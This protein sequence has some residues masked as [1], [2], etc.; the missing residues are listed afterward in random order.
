MESNHSNKHP[1]Q[2]TLSILVNGAETEIPKGFTVSDLVAEMGLANKRVAV[3]RNLDIVPRSQH[4][5][6]VLENN[7]K[8]EV[9]EA[10][11]GG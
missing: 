11:G 4:D 6:V 10:I 2:T 8:I 9:V 3:E 5:A 7:D 1:N